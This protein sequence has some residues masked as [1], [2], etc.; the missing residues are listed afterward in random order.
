MITRYYCFFSSWNSVG[1]EKSCG[2][3]DEVSNASGCER[4]TGTSTMQWYRG[5]FWARNTMSVRRYRPHTGLVTKQRIRNN[6]Y[7][8]GLG[9]IEKG[10]TPWCTWDINLPPSSSWVLEEFGYP[11][12]VDEISQAC[13]IRLYSSVRFA[14]GS[15]NTPRILAASLTVQ[16][17]FHC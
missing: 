6:A 16:P 10:S 9:G 13:V 12:I 15:V 8:H 2:T 17:L 7:A 5:C 11:V 3:N 14:Y 4:V 1:P